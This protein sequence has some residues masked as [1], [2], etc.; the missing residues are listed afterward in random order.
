MVLTHPALTAS[1]EIPERIMKSKT[2][3]TVLED[4][5]E[6]PTTPF[7]TR[8]LPS[9]SNT[10][11]IQTTHKTY[12]IDGVNSLIK[13]FSLLGDEKS[14]SSTLKEIHGQ[15]PIDAVA[16][17]AY[18]CTPL[19][20]GLMALSMK[21]DGSFVPQIV[22][23]LAANIS[24]A[25]FSAAWQ[26]TVDSNAN[27]RTTFVQ[28][29]SSGLIQVVLKPAQ[30]SWQPEN[31]LERYLRNDRQIPTRFGASLLR[32]GMVE[33]SRSTTRHFIWT[34]HHAV[35]DGWAMRLLFKQVDQFYRDDTFDPL[36][37]FN[38]FIAQQVRTDTHKSEQFWS[39]HLSN[40]ISRPFPCSPSEIYLPKADRTLDL[41]IS[42]PENIRAIATTSTIIQAAWAILISRHTNTAEATFGLVLAG[43]N[44]DMPGI[45]RISGPTFATVP[46][47]VT[48][49]SDSSVVEFFSAIHKERVAMK[50]HQYIGLQ[51]I[52]RLGVDIARACN[53][54]NLLVIQPKLERDRD[55]LFD[56]RYNTSDHWAKLNAYAL[57][58]QCDLEDDGFT[59]RASFDS[60]VVTENEM[61]GIL[62]DFENV[63]RHFSASSIAP[64]RNI[65]LQS[66]TTEN[67]L[68]IW[69]SGAE[70]VQSCVHD[71]IWQNTKDR[72]SDLAVTSWDGE[73][74]YDQLHFM[75]DQLAWHLR[76]SMV[77]PEVK[78]VLV[79]EKSLW[80]VVAMMA[81]MKAGGVFV[82]LD[83]THPK[84]R[85]QSLVQQIGGNLLLCSEKLIASF[86]GIANETI[87]V[88]L[89]I[90]EQLP[91]F[92]GSLCTKVGPSNAV[93][94]KF[95]SEGIYPITD[96]LYFAI[97]GTDKILLPASKSDIL[98]SYPLNILG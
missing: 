30:I 32:F 14:L 6:N 17:D 54:Q 38:R 51:N 34:F 67:S 37:D 70:E 24:L 21:Q 49:D 3:S 29:R 78:V 36:I 42:V 45:K 97:A 66:S 12:Q 48:I 9:S 98:R 90:L 44:S 8:N 92:E 80:T 18:P 43:R 57:M 4:H 40:S 89:S 50:P 81:V 84:L 82:C 95:I 33:D 7:R 94:G 76:S 87:A 41:H 63:I 20:E 68:A 93:D 15:I 62:Q 73:L 91:T 88:G 25:K 79:F 53:F 16:V 52:R 69:N 75:S 61:Q 5:N 13:P 2:I 77:G 10:S 35:I 47:R 85:I 96:H 65:H 72:L 1:C 74:T 55:S 86:S 11:N 71:V 83:P 27:L 59:A 60:E 39:R 28:T 26:A 19:Q 22:C 56:D 46:M 31:N 23:K 58:M 64:L